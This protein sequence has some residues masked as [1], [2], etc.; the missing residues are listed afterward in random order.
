MTQ[1]TPRL[2]AASLVDS[3]PAL[4]GFI[5]EHSLCLIALGAGGIVRAT[6]RYDL[7]LTTGGDLAPDLVVVLGNLGEIACRNDFR[8]LVAV[9]VDD[10]FDVD[11][12]RYRR[13]LAA[14][15]E[16]CRVAGGI[17]QGFV[18]SEHSANGIWQV[19]WQPGSRGPTSARLGDN[20]V[21]G[22][23]RIS[24]TAIAEAFAS[25][26]YVLT[27]RSEMADMLAPLPHCDSPSCGA[28]IALRG[29]SGPRVPHSDSADLLRAALAALDD[30]PD[31]CSAVTELARAILTLEVRD[32]LMACAVTDQRPAAEALW[33]VLARRLRG[34][35]RASAA[36]LLAHLH[37]IGGEG[38]YAGVALDC[39]LDADPTWSMAVLLDRALRN[40]LHPA[41]LGT[42]IGECF[43]VAARLGVTLPPA[44]LTVPAA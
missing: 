36:T 23:P 1:H 33:R 4:L 24:P 18:V 42:M 12:P 9:I 39:A 2:S 35:A 7:S 8:R 14:A 26:R 32:A 34:S 37:Y 16:A 17:R 27:R 43:E 15:D 6:M 19:V 22:D 13:V 10:R 44:T 29:R 25:G 11:D 41:E 38:A 28:P 31:T 3:V 40:G 30:P 5:P 20:G 21:M